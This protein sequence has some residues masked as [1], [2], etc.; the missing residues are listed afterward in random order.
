MKWHQ[1]SSLALMQTG[2]QEDIAKYSK[3]TIRVTQQHNDECKRLLTL[4]GV[5][6]INVSPIMLKLH[7]KLQGRMSVCLKLLL[8]AKRL[9]IT[10]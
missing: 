10:V 6:I 7:A 4:M 5:P 9:H 3:R 1:H 8:A 2:N